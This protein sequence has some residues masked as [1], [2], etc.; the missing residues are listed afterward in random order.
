MSVW[1]LYVGTFTSEFQW[2]TGS[3]GQGIE[4]F[5]FD[6]T[7]GAMQQLDTTTGV[8]SPQ[9]LTVHPARPVVY[10]AEFAA[11]GKLTLFGIRPDGSLERLSASSSLGAL[12]VAVSIHPSTDFAYL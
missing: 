3:P 11:E 9:Y 4:R 6:D 12:A 1:N 7:T 10:A 5:R 8:L 2:L